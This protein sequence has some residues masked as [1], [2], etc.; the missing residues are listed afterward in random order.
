MFSLCGWVMGFDG[1]NYRF[2]F[3]W[4]SLSMR[5]AMCTKTHVELLLF[6]PFSIDVPSIFVLFQFISI[7]IGKSWKCF[8]DRNDCFEP[9]RELRYV[10]NVKTAFFPIRGNNHMDRSFYFTNKFVTRTVVI[11]LVRLVLFDK[12][13]EVE[14]FNE[15]DKENGK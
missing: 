4:A 10:C 5:L 1:K 6:L 8:C 3:I 2:F 9:Y 12:S 13:N 15:F 7:F 14:L 11:Q